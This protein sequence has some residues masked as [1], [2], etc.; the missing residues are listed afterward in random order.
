MKRNRETLTVEDALENLTSISEVDEERLLHVMDGSE[1]LLSVE[2]LGEKTISL[3]TSKES[4]RTIDAIRETLRVL[5]QYMRDMYKKHGDDEVDESSL[6]GIR[7]IMLLVGDAA[8]KLSSYTNI[9]KGVHGEAGLNSLKEYRDLQQF[10]RSKIGREEKEEALYE[11]MFAPIEE[12]M[13]SYKEDKIMERSEIEEALNDLNVVKQDTDYEFFFLKKE[14]GDHFFDRRLLR[15]IRMACNFEKTLD[16]D[17]FTEDPLIFIKN[18]QDKDFQICAK[19]VLQSIRGHLDEFYKEAFRYKD[20]SLVGLI[21]KAIMALFLTANPKNLLRHVAVKSCYQY[22]SDFRVFLRE[23]LASPDY[24][25][26]IA[27]PPDESKRMLVV[28]VKLIHVMSLE[29]YTHIYAKSELEGMI[30]QLV[31]ADKKDVAEIPSKYIH[32]H[33]DALVSLLEAHPNGPVFKVLDILMEGDI[34]HFNPLMQ[35]NTPHKLFDIY[36]SD[37]R[38]SVLRVPS[39]THQE[40]VDKADVLDEFKGFLRYYD[41]CDGNR[42][43]LMFNLQ[44]R[45]SWKEHARSAALEEIHLQAEF[46]RNIDV[47]TMALDTEFYHQLPPYHELSEASLFISQFN[48]HVMSDGTGYYFPFEMR[49]ELFPAFIEEAMRFIYVTFFQG[50]KRLERKERQAFIDIF[51]VCLFM[52]IIEL[53]RPYSVSF[54]CKDGVDRSSVENTLL[55][56]FLKMMFA[57]KVDSNDMINLDLM[58]FAPALLIRERCVNKV[59]FNRVFHALEVMEGCANKNNVF[60]DKVREGFAKLYGK[61]FQ[62][63]DVIFPTTEEQ[64]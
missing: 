21:N 49:K 35:D 46:N 63:I 52:K 11:E 54:T 8:S 27:Y 22:F 56:I 26:L 28:L 1:Y 34:P 39:P 32:Q 47:V 60:S 17:E 2:A 29:L 57:S 5:F 18:W 48:D 59:R 20:M 13:V 24:K 36:A 41:S 40:F 14:S 50:K 55:Y 12:S 42:S 19:N 30:S 31:M 62:K 33:Y 58:L 23:A 7:S 51:Y 6:L 45:T 64:F 15:N 38:L 16:A 53:E 37:Y 25:K 43:H 61:G 9:F 3:L 10:Y 44:D 4:S